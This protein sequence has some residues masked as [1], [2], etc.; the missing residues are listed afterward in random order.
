MQKETAL[1]HNQTEKVQLCDKSQ[2]K[3]CNQ[4]TAKVIPC[5]EFE[6]KGNNCDRNVTETVQICKQTHT[7]KRNATSLEN[8]KFCSMFESI[9]YNA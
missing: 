5:V 9:K 6:A 1:C 3:L 4:V 7:V 2:Q 8:P